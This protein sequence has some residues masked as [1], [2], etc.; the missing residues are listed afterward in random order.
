MRTTTFDAAA[1]VV[2]AFS[3]PVLGGCSSEVDD[4][5]PHAGATSASS[6]SVVASSGEGGAGGGG[7]ATGSG[8]FVTADHEPFPQLENAGGPILE[9]AQLV[10]VTYPD[11]PYTADVEAFGDW[12]VGSDWLT[13]VG[14][15]YGV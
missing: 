13:I 9:H 1:I 8:G 2:L 11:Y 14:A 6:T 10:T 5:V 7:G 3:I 12:V 15:E 4:N